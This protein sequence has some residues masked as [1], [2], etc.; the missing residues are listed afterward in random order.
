M[1]CCHKCIVPNKPQIL[2]E[3]IPYSDQWMYHFHDQTLEHHSPCFFHQRKP[4]KPTGTYSGR[5]MSLPSSALCLARRVELFAIA[6]LLATWSIWQGFAMAVPHK[7]GGFCYN[8]LPLFTKWVVSFITSYH[9]ERFEIMVHCPT[10]FLLIDKSNMNF[11]LNRFS[12]KKF[13][14]QIKRWW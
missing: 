14:W 3:V 2:W 6:L 13:S 5:A 12:S 10:C 1:T 7:K 11:I 8:N 4:R 9:F